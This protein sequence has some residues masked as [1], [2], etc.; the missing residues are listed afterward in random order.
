MIGRELSI[1]AVNAYDRG[2]F[3]RTIDLIAE[4]KLETTGWVETVDFEE[5]VSVGYPRLHQAAA[6]KVLVSVAG[7]SIS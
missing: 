4:G 6:A 3:A 5:T 7:E 1:V 2:D